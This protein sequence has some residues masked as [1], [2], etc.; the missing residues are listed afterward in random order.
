MGRLDDALQNHPGLFVRVD[1]AAGSVLYASAQFS[2][3][4]ELVKAHGVDA[5]PAFF[6]W[7]QGE[8]EFRALSAV[9]PA[10]AGLRQ[11]MRIW[12]A[13][14]T[15]HHAHFIS[16]L[17]AALWLYAGLA[18]G[19][20]GMLGWWAARTALAERTLADGREFLCAGRFTA[21]DI[22]VAYALLFAGNLGHL[23]LVG[24][25]LRHWWSRLQERPGFRAAK[26]RQ[27]AG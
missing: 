26:A 10:H 12:V 4:A 11:D 16:A 21:A 24:E 8:R 20:S 23:E 1:E 14:D 19:L 25:N 27:A 7:L 9:A 18:A 22:S 17:R 6:T 15:L 13:L 3:P 5:G 2:F